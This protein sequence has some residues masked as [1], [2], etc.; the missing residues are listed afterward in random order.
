MH[1]FSVLTLAIFVAGYITARWDLVTR[2]YELAN[3]AWDHGVVTRTAKGFAILSLFFFLFIIPLERLASRETHSWESVM[4]DHDGLMR[5]F[6]PSDL[7]RSDA[8]GIIVGWRNS[9]LD[10]FVVAI[11]EE[12]DAR[13][14]ENALKV[15]TLFRSASH[16]IAR[17]YELCGRPSMEVLGLANSPQIE[18]E[19]LQIHASK[20]P[21]LRMPQISCARA[22]TVQI[23]MFERP[24]PNR[25]QYISLNPI[26]LALGDKAEKTNHAPGSVDAEEEK[27]EM[28]NRARTKH[29]V[30]K[31]RLHTVSIHPPSQKEQALP[32]IVNQINCSFE[33]NKL[34]QKNIS[35]VG[36]RS[37]RSLS[38]SERVVESATGMRDFVI[39][40][41]WRVMTLYIYPIIRR[42]FILGLVCHRFTAEALLLVLE[43]R[44]KPDYAA[45][46]DISA[47]AQQVEIRLQ[48]F[49]Y[50]PVQYITLRKR[51][52]DWESVTTSHPDY[53]RFYNSL[54]LVAND[55][56]IGI[57]LGSYIIDN[58]AWVAESISEFLSL[59]S[60][61]VL[62]R[63]IAWLMDWPAGLKLNNE[64]AAFLG[65]LFLWVIDHWSNCLEA[66]RPVLP[67]L[68]WFIGFSSFAGAS[69]P[70]ALFSDLLSI[71]TIHIYSFYMA[72]ARIFNW[73]YTILLSLFQL[74]RG[75]KHN[76][77]RKRIDSCDYDL[78]QLLLGT[79]LFTLL[80]FLL[81]TVIV[82][83]LT[84]ACSRMATISL[85]AVLDT[86]L[87]CLNHF[88]L[89]ALMLRIKD[90]QRLPGGICFELK[91]TQQLTLSTPTTDSHGPPPTSYIYL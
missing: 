65:D 26:S 7:S 71:L 54:W 82:F 56:I 34:L 9:G 24:L 25:M 75:K 86:L 55:V 48:Q 58:S 67:H 87:A 91:D 15:G 13:S 3:F 79:I 43:W 89:F 78:D 17:I 74:F 57:A 60:I 19:V 41:L 16:P 44:A 31:L 83:Y 23:I 27:E 40:A 61:A 38:V 8:P 30:E 42:G 20:G 90:S 1:P 72:S 37:R 88:P 62:R 80:F 14:V 47:T 66:L 59:Y 70:I 39:V 73:Q 12:V 76:V 5:I 63:T 46:K 6:W 28:K 21:H 29:L 45:L 49:C 85:K 53:I 11:L 22:S 52:N 69:M 33:L 36:R 51:K 77:L 2:L 50:W 35:L 10:V 18:V 81:P 64:L 4:P 68:I 84:F 32:R